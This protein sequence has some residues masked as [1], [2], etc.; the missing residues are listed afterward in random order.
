[1]KLSTYNIVLKVPDENKILLF[2]SLTNSLVALDE[3]Y[4]DIFE[5]KTSFGLEYIN[6]LPIFETLVE[7]GYVLD[8]EVNE[9][10]IIE[11]LYNSTKFGSENKDITIAPTLNCDFDCVYC[12]EQGVIQKD[13]DMSQAVQEEL[14]SYFE[15]AANKFRSLSVTWFGGEPSLA[16]DVILSLSK[17]F[18]KIAIEKNI[19]YD[20]SMTSNGYSLVPVDATIDILKECK[21]N[22]I[23]ITIDGIPTIHNKRR[24]LKNSKEGT[25][26]RI[27][28]N[29]KFLHTNGVQVLIRVNVDKTNLESSEGLLD[30]L[31]DNGLQDIPISLGEVQTDT[32]ACKFYTENCLSRKQFG[33]GNSDFH[34]ALKTRG[35]YSGSTIPYPSLSF[36]CVANRMNSIIF[37]A[38][39]DMYKCRADIGDKSQVIGNV[40]K[41]SKRTQDKRMKEINWINWSPF[42]NKRC[43]ECKLLPICLG[44]C[45]HRVIFDGKLDCTEWKYN[46]KYFLKQKYLSNI[47]KMV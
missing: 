45:A 19:R 20:A 2:N 3:A 22:N 24:R 18:V 32:I 8:D 25:F 4:K 12:Y 41:I 9:L 23:Q 15:E 29:V 11:Y 10:S 16:I 35:F 1:M 26:Q 44:G 37:D 39:G 21:I 30:I 47:T 43:L 42:K 34:Q 33:L 14:V 7:G 46:L 5:Q 27:L 17:R 13:S 6:G 36:P 38:D 31:K 40:A 28:E